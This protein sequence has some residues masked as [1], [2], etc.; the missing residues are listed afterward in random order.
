MARPKESWEGSETSEANIQYLRDTKRRPPPTMV[1]ARAAGGE[2][3]PRPQEGERIVF[4]TH[5]KRRFSL[6]V[7][8]FFR[9]FLNFFM[10]QPHYLGANVVLQLASFA[11]LDEG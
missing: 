4:N 3:E 9:S 11:M 6:P 5:F 2:M 8:T 10:L 7:S 1:A